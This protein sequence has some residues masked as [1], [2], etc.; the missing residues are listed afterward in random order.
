MRSFN[1]LIHITAYIL[2]FCHLMFRDSLQVLKRKMVNS[3]PIS[4]SAQG[5]KAWLLTLL[6]ITITVMTYITTTNNYRPMLNKS[7]LKLYK[8]PGNVTD[9]GKWMNTSGPVPDLAQLDITVAIGLAITSKT[10]HTK[11]VASRANLL[12]LMPFFSHLLPSFC[13]T[14][15]QGFTYSFY[16]AYDFNDN[17]FNDAKKRKLWV[18]KFTSYTKT[19]CEFLGKINCHFVKCNYSGRPA[20]AQN[21]AMM[22]AYR[23]RRDFFYRVNDDTVMTSSNWTHLFIAELRK[24]DPPLVGV[25]GPTHSGGNTGIL[26]YDFVHRTHI[27][28]F[29]FYYPREF[30]GWYADTWITKVYLPRRSKKLRSVRLRHIVQVTRYD[31]HRIKSEYFSSVIKKSSKVLEGY[32][33]NKQI[34]ES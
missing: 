29:G 13:R 17:F 2:L 32:L 19:H 11:V 12:K 14:A 31:V 24:M 7:A 1:V 6:I 25:V 28:I 27:D 15:S 34:R 16:L 23:D 33:A 21:D 20:W 30:P 5:L 9:H 18:D 3:Q 8:I 22:A 26:T 10:G 4:S